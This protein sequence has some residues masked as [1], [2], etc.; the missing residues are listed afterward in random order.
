MVRYFYSI[1]TIF[2]RLLTPLL[3]SL[4]LFSAA[5]ETVQAQ[6]WQKLATF[7]GYISYCTFLNDSIG[8]I[9][10][11]LSPGM[12]LPT[13]P[14]NLY[15]T[16]DGGTT[17]TQVTTPTGYGGEI[18]NIVMVDANNGWLAMT[19]YGGNGNKALW[20]T[21]DGGLTWNETSLVGSGT[22][23]Q[24]TPSAIV[25][26]DIFNN[27]HISTDGG[28]TWQ[29]SPYSSTTDVAFV[30]GTHGA[31]S[32]FRG[33]SWLY[34]SDGGL[35]WN[36]SNMNIESWSIYGVKG[37]SN[38]YAAP[39]GNT[40]PYNGQIYKSTDYGISWNSVT[41]LTF[42]FT[43]DI[44]GLGD[45]WLFFQA[46]WW[47]R[48]I[49][50]GFDYSTDQGKN[51][52]NI[53]GPN[54]LADTRFAV[55][56]G[57]N[58]F[59]IYG[60]G[61]ENGNTLYR[62]TM[63]GSDSASALP[64]VASTP[65][66]IV[67]GCSDTS[68]WELLSIGCSQFRIDS[69]KIE[70]DTAG[71]FHVDSLPH[72]PRL[73]GVNGSDSVHVI[74][75]PSHSGTFGARL[76][77]FGTLLGSDSSYDTVIN[78]LATDSSASTIPEIATKPIP[79]VAGCIDTSVWELL[80]VGCSQFQIDSVEIEG[81]TGNVFRLDPKQKLPRLIDYN[82]SDSIHVFFVPDGRAGTFGARLHLH[83]TLAGS[84]APFDTIINL[85]ATST[86]TGNPLPTIRYTPFAQVQSCSAG[87]AYAF[88]RIGCA[89]FRIDSVKIEADTANVFAVDPTQK[90]PQML[91]ANN[92]DS[93]HVLFHPKHRLGV[94]GAKL[95]LYGTDIGSGASFDT[96]LSL[97]AEST[98]PIPLFYASTGLYTWSSLPE[99]SRGDT[100]IQFKNYGCDTV[101]ADSLH[102]VPG[103]TLTSQGLTLPVLVPPN[104]S[105]S[106]GVHF[107]P[108][109]LL[110][111][112]LSALL[113]Y[114]S[115]GYDDSIPVQ[116]VAQAHPA[117]PVLISS[118]SKVN[119]GPQLSCDTVDTVV[120]FKN[121]GC[122]SLTITNISSLLNGF[123]SDPPLAFPITLAKGDSL[124]LHV[125]YHPISA[126]DT[127]TVFVRT[128]S[129]NQKREVKINLAGQ[130][131]IGELAVL[132]P[133]VTLS[134]V[135]ICGSADTTVSIANPSC[136]TMIITSANLYP[137]GDVQLVGVTLP[138]VLPPNSDTTIELHFAAKSAENF[139]T[140]LS[141]YYEDAGIK[142][143][144]I[145][146]SIIAIATSPQEKLA[147]SDTAISIASLPICMSDS[148]HAMLYNPGCDTLIVSANE[149]DGDPDFILLSGLDSVRILPQDSVR[150]NLAV[151]PQLKGSRNA[152]LHI[153]YWNSL[154]TA[155]KRDSVI[156]FVAFITNGTSKLMASLASANLGTIGECASADTVVTLR[157]VG[158]DTLTIDTG[159]LNNNYFVLVPNNVFPIH[160]PPYSSFTWQLQT[161][162]D[163][164]GHPANL[165]SNLLFTSRDTTIA[166]IPLTY[167][168]RYAVPMDLSLVPMT[169]AQLADSQV[170]Y[171]I[172]N[173]ASLAG[174]GVND[175]R[176]S[177]H[178][179][180][181]VLGFKNFEGPN[182]VS[183]DSTIL[184]GMI[185]Y[186]FNIT[187]SPITQWADGTLARLWF[188]T[189]VALESHTAIW[190]DSAHL[191]PG[192]SEFERCTAYL[193]PSA[194]D[195]TFELLPSCGDSALRS[196]MSGQTISMSVRTF[197]GRTIFAIHS[198]EARASGT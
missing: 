97:L 183:E 155:G 96:V 82:R 161:N 58:G 12:P 78:L 125:R 131:R 194:T 55:L 146:I 6:Q 129:G 163:T 165:S 198:P 182:I 51:W 15:R 45:N 80:S 170:Y 114:S 75:D 2:E 101:S 72:L 162:L 130:I 119:F 116:I 159:T 176:F 154:G 29:S 95:E 34:S 61:D 19:S 93:V 108:D 37:T 147:L 181:D 107:V 28:S 77:L 120:Y 113:Y 4:I 30:D 7:P 91:T 23:V 123:S 157:N 150:V 41:T 109:G 25:V 174:L 143:P 137:T 69:A 145:D 151:V 99:C 110:S 64:Q 63:G 196:L 127:Q 47:D 167:A 188:R 141:L 135:A 16:T 126:R 193:R 103:L 160:I 139:S 168:V 43:G 40:H 156:D 85:Q 138:I 140:T 105:I 179:A 112:S 54:T 115:P 191:N 38:F 59:T 79:P 11:G 136:D 5:T 68:V 186:N 87:D 71:V 171:D 184:N 94:F 21:T 3:L 31:M 89:Q 149:L 118:T 48:S 33:E 172:R 32:D 76:H 44:E 177:L 90:F 148:L 10:L 53:G 26:S 49:S 74:F 62:Y 14:I 128:Q 98:L 180:Q 192:D 84:G 65:I 81:D 153:H 70:R 66:P 104:G 111:D 60:Y 24:V 185:N 164:A 132:T 46:H 35:T 169:G 1:R 175:V 56:P 142:E 17:W 102:L 8:F 88:Y 9:G 152:V 133:S 39:E 18:G 86:S 124:A 50:P 158:C 121:F 92:S 22:A 189:Y 42:K 190:I 117:P 83:G 187:G 67:K 134:S 20:R 166:P 122:D 178:V 52:T 106:L 57:C 73:V 100:V 144:H 195:T 197:G 27:I 36:T 13:P 173:T